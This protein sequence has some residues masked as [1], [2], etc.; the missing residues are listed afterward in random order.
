MSQN[1]NNVVINHV[2]GGTQRDKDALLGCFFQFFTAG[3][4]GFCDRHGKQKSTAPAGYI[5]SGKEFKFI[6]DGCIWTIKNLDLNSNSARGTWSND[7]GIQIHVGE[8]NTFT[9]QAGS[10]L[11]YEAASS[12]RG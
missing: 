10:N 11:D 4:W 12:A 9:A 1:Q 5:Y 8:D 6:L 3:E 2:D 7:R